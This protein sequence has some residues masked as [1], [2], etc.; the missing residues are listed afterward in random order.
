[1]GEKA[2]VYIPGATCL[3]EE[4]KQIRHVKKGCMEGIEVADYTAEGEG[5]LGSEAGMFLISDAT[6]GM[7]D[8]CAWGGVGGRGGEGR[9]D[10]IDGWQMSGR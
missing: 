6:C 9:S 2:D 3:K 7:C 1:M 10:G 5:N 4:G 8:V